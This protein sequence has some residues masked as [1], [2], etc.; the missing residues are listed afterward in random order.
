MSY[1]LTSQAL[2]DLEDIADFLAKEYP[3][4]A[5][6]IE[7]EFRRIFALAAEF[8]RLGRPGP[9][10]GTRELPVRRYPY[11]VIFRAAGEHIDI[12][13]IFHTARDPATKLS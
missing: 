11:I 5:P 12:L 3:A 1:R 4:I 13:R 8:P 7:D 10:P 6:R 2:T 9:R